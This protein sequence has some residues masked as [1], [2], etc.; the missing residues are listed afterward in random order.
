MEEF[1]TVVTEF[2]KCKLSRLNRENSWDL[3]YQ[4]AWTKRLKEGGKLFVIVL[5]KKANKTKLTS[6]ALDM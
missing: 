2:F 6:Y 1:E 4:Y 3:V 5:F